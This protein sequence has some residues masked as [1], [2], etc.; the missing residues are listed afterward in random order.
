MDELHE[1]HLGLVVPKRHAKRSVTRSLV[2]RQIRSGMRQCAHLLAAGDWVL[3]LRA[4]LDRKV[5]T[6]ACSD[7]LAEL[8]RAEIVQLLADAA[9]RAPRLAR[10]P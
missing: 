10:G 2:K 9:R 3:R 4:P 8:V 1:L 7:A 5:Y 6:S